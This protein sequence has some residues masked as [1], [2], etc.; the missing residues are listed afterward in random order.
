MVSWE[1]QD[2]AA[3]ND[4]PENELQMETII[5]LSDFSMHSALRARMTVSKIEINLYF[6]LNFCS[7]AE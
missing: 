1:V 3:R 4:L 6:F 2:K 7:N 5:S